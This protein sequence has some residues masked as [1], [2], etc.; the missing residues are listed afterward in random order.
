MGESPLFCFANNQV[1][2]FEL[3]YAA[4]T[5]WLFGR[6]L[7]RKCCRA[8]VIFSK[9]FVSALSQAVLTGKSPHTEPGFRARDVSGLNFI[10][11]LGEILALLKTIRETMCH[12][13]ARK[14]DPQE[15]QGLSR[16]DKPRQ[17]KQEGRFGVVF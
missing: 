3:F 11:G 7:L 14:N 2:G 15:Q 12:E 8:G 13:C 6:W 5:S 10:P 1:P 9:P 16:Q 17:Q 4:P